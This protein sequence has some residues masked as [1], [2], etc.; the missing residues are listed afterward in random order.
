VDGGG[1]NLQLFTL[2]SNFLIHRSLIVELVRYDF[3]YYFIMTSQFYMCEFRPDLLFGL[4]LTLNKR[5]M[6]IF[7]HRV[8]VV[9]VN[10]SYK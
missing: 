10:L 6:F 8:I 3:F 5:E 9:V 4:I 2:D 7:H 1:N